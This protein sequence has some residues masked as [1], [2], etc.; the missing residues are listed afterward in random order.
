MSTGVVRPEVKELLND[1]VEMNDEVDASQPSMDEAP[2][3]MGQLL[4][5][6]VEINDDVVASQPSMDDAPTQT[7]QLLNEDVEINDKVDASRPRMD[8]APS[9]IE[10]TERPSKIEREEGDPQ[11]DVKD[12]SFVRC[13]CLDEIIDFDVTPVV[14]PVDD[15]DE[16]V[17]GCVRREVTRLY[18]LEIPDFLG[19]WRNFLL[20]KDRL[21]R[22][23]RLAFVHYL[24]TDDTKK[25]MLIKY[26]NANDVPMYFKNDIRYDVMMIIQGRARIGFPMTNVHPSLIFM[27]TNLRARIGHQAGWQEV[28]T[29]E[30]KEDAV[31]RCLT[32]MVSFIS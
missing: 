4:N 28:E 32:D 24:E 5:D 27:M 20:L 25:Q 29:S 14:M 10:R 19:E 11:V 17:S 8:D 23:S 16:T 15:G 21:N 9:R 26:L 1:E 6:E 12:V 2:T 22:S 18:G 3:R 7:E 30:G 31:R 13:D